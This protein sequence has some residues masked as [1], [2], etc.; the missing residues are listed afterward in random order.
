MS[1]DLLQEFAQNLK[2]T[3]Q[4]QA[5]GDVAAEEDD[6]FGDFEDP[7]SVEKPDAIPEHLR[8]P[9]DLISLS[10]DKQTGL[11]IEDQ[12]QLP[13][14]VVKKQALDDGDDWGDFAGGSV[15]FDADQAI[16]KGDSSMKSNEVSIN[17]S[18]MTKPMKVSLLPIDQR[19]AN[20]GPTKPV[21]EPTAD[22]YDY[23]QDDIWEPTEI[24]QNPMIPANV[25]TITEPTSATGP[26]TKQISK[27]DRRMSGPPPFNI[28]PPSVLLPSIA[29]YFQS[30]PSDIKTL[31]SV[32]GVSTDTSKALSQ[33]QID[34]LKEALA[35]A[36]AG[37]RVLA[38]RKLR[39][40]RDNL[41][42]QSMKIGPAG[43][44]SSGMKLTGVDK[45]ESRRED[46]EAAEVLDVWRKQVGP[47]R[48]II[49]VVNSQ[50]LETGLILPDISENIPIR[51]MKPSEGAVT[52]PKGCFLCGIKRDERVAKID[53]D[54]E[55][56][57]GEWWCEYWGHV[58]CMEFWEKYRG[59]LPQR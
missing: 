9:A 29:R 30:L 49:S 17:P 23:T 5:G 27:A 40:K 59:S 32:P 18:D 46:Q 38:G 55:D 36:R 54:V 58:D 25:S 43:G 48:S 4:S 39:W 50:H 34:Q 15:L 45:G 3:A 51:V 47:L 7:E 33:L 2:S 28:P 11:E 53:V 22:P 26:S 13:S 10:G 37:G 6:D 19:R 42:S 20:I 56:S 12:P 14:S 35:R 24:K 16:A 41:L 8:N 57:F 21:P 31:T 44:K 52:A 1:S